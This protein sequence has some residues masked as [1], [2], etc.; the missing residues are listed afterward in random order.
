MVQSV[1]DDGLKYS[2]P[3]DDLIIAQQSLVLSTN[4]TTPYTVRQLYPV[5]TVNRDYT[6]EICIIDQFIIPK[7]AYSSVSLQLEVIGSDGE[8]FFVQRHHRS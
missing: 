2:P 3:L 1:V 6:I 4:I 8:L 7:F 5:V